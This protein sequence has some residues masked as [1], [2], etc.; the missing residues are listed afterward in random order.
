MGGSRFGAIALGL[1]AIG[2]VGLD[3]RRRPEAIY[4]APVAIGLIIS[5]VY[6]CCEARWSRL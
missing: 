2:L 6:S 5:R 3:L 4:G 1:L